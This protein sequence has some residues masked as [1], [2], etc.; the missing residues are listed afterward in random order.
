MCTLVHMRSCAAPVRNLRK[1]K[2]LGAA[3][4]RKQVQKRRGLLR[5]CQ[6]KCKNVVVGLRQ[7]ISA[8]ALQCQDEIFDIA[9]II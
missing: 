7:I 1:C 3:P 9:A 8:K 6:I 5:Q 4:V 2:T